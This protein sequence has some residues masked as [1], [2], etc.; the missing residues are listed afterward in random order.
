MRW[1]GLLIILLLGSCAAPPKQTKVERERLSDEDIDDILDEP[2]DVE[3]QSDAH[4]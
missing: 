1:T 2:V 3:T 4:G